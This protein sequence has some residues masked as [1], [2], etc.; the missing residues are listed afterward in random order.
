MAEH[1]TV[2]P[3]GTAIL[4]EDGIGTSAW[5]SY[6]IA[7]LPERFMDDREDLAVEYV[8]E[9]GT[10]LPSVTTIL[11]AT[12]E[13]PG[14]Q[15]AA[16]RMTAKA[17]GELAKE[18]KLPPS[19]DEVW[20]VLY[21]EGLTFRQQWDNKADRGTLTHED[22]VHIAEGRE[23]PSLNTY[24]PE[25]QQFVRGL[26]CFLADL[27]P[28]IIESEQMVASLSHGYAGRCDLVVEFEAQRFP[29]GTPTPQG[30]GLVDLKT[31]EKLP[32]TKPSKTYPDGQLKTPYPENFLQL[33]LY[34]VARRECGLEAT[35]WQAILTVD[36]N[37]DYDF[38]CSWLQPEAAL[39]FI[40]AYKT[41]KAVGSRVKRPADQL[42]VGLDGKAAA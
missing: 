25:Q 20:D 26:A 37:G 18:G 39:D 2:T 8:R 28:G 33:G 27:R 10:K 29:D 4:F 7:Q 32:R 31:H 3:T 40:P 14:L 38:T 5:R 9:H 6:R 15:W 21:R 16:A 42:P 1:L 24:P 11:G 12:I 34:E 23:L 19:P 35:D 41:F 36:A 22:L 30:R 13:K 17:C